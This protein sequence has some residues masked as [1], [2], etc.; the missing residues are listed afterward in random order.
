MDRLTRF[1]RRFTCAFSLFV[2]FPA[3]L[4][5]IAASLP[6]DSRFSALQMLRFVG[7]EGAVLNAVPD[8]VLLDRLALRYILR[9]RQAGGAQ[10]NPRHSK[11]E[12]FVFHNCPP[13]A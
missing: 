10:E 4:S 8:A 12:Q 9:L 7:S 11:R 1:C 3:V 6:V 5:A 2:K 13:A